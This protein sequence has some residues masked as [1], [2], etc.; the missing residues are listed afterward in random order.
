MPPPSLPLLLFLLLLLL[1][2]AFYITIFRHRARSPPDISLCDNLFFL[3]FF[4]SRFSPFLLASSLCF[5]SSSLS[6][7]LSIFFSFL[8]P[9]VRRSFLEDNARP[10][11]LHFK[12]E[13]ESRTGRGSIANRERTG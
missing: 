6:L 12:C 10:R 4:P 7:F 11:T 9:F 13:R 8:L 2:T 1:V 5:T 3:P